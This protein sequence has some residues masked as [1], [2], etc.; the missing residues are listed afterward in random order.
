MNVSIRV[1]PLS[2]REVAN[3][4]RDIIRA[5]DNLLIVLDMNDFEDKKNVLHRSREQRYVFNKVFIG[6]NNEEVYSHTV[7]DLIKPALSGINACVFAYGCT[8][9]GKTY[10]MLGTPEDTGIGILT[11]RDMFQQIQ[12]D[13]EKIYD[14]K[15]SYVEIYNEAIRDLLTPSS[16]YLDLRDDPQKGVLIAGVSEY[17][18]EST[19]QVMNLLTSGNKRR[20][21]EATNANQT[22]SRSHAIFQIMVSQRDRTKNTQLDVFQ[23]KL[24]LID[25]AGSERGTVTE[26][27]GIRLWEGAKI[28]RSLLALANCI[29]ALGDKSKK[30]FFVPYRD[31]KLTRLLKDSLGG[32]CK[33]VMISNISPASSQFEETINTLKYSSRAKNI[34]YKV[35]PN[36]KMVSIHI[37]E[38]KSII[39]DLRNEIDVLKNQLHRGS[40]QAVVANNTSE[41]ECVCTC[42]RAQDDLE[43]KRLQTEIFENFQE[44]IQL[45]RGLLELE[46]QNAL[47]SLEIKKRQ[48]E[49]MIWK[50]QEELK[51]EPKSSGERPLS[52]VPPNVRKQ[53][54]EIQQLKTST[55]SNIKR[56]ERM[57]VQLQENMGRG[58]NIRSSIESR[59]KFQDK[60]DFLELQ[61]KNHILEQTNVELE[62]QLQIQEKTISDLQN[63]VLAQKKLLEE[64]GIDD[65]SNLWDL[66]NLRNQ[67]E[68]SN[69]T[70]EELEMEGYDITEP[71]DEE[72][73]IPFDGDEDFER[74]EM[75][76]ATGKIYAD[77]EQEEK[78]DFMLQGKSLIKKPQHEEVKL[79]PSNS[80]ADPTPS[81]SESI[82]LM[83][84]GKIM[85]DG[86][87]KKTAAKPSIAKP[88]KKKNP[89]D[90][91]RKK[92]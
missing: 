22:S 48:A 28:N 2:A 70:E 61:I 24:S 69:L 54:K 38:Y 55:D 58:K 42:G 26:N 23:G 77:I 44:R 59:I 87:Q 12:E 49:V 6:V 3:G 30:G 56:K 4:D 92:K 27:R 74:S 11:I 19:E 20:T 89:L 81:P 46:E 29:N 8:G 43:M 31:S 63:L 41:N 91:Y 62:L 53:F 57:I 67:Q 39:A 72:E 13:S 5:E 60:R 66:S 1:R 25:L 9:S 73:E 34:K 90:V 16:G 33:T 64:N 82:G 85:Q 88:A 7:H 80:K 17:S 32:N 21:T 65:G 84:N 50:K 18:A 76:L 36:K 45:R 78:E 71:L 15:I 10:T 40:G 86:L 83:I 14:I 47:N 52:A 75:L 37:A 35:Q 51:E 68:D 79:K